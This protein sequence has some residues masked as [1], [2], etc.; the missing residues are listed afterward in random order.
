METFRDTLNYLYHLQFSG[1]KLGL[2]NIGKLLSYLGNPQNRWPA[3]H[4]AG[5][6][7][8]GSTAAFV[9]SILKEAGYRVALYTSPHLVDFRERIRVN[10]RFIPGEELVSYTRQLKPQIEKVKPT[11]FE[12]TT[13][14][15]FRYFADQN[16]DVAVVETG[17][18]GRLDATNLVNP[19]LTL[20]TSIGLDHQQY[21]GTDLPQIAREKAGIIKPG[22]PCF[23][24]NRSAEVLQVLRQR[25]REQ[26]APFHPLNP[27]EAIDICSQSIYGSTFHLQLPDVRLLDLKIRLAGPFQVANAALAVA[28]L[29]E[30][31]NFKI[32]EQNLR[33]GIK[34]AEWKGRLQ[35]VRD[36]P[37]VIVDVAH[38]PD[39]FRQVFDFLKKQLPNRPIR[40]MV[41]LAKDK[42][43]RQIAS[44]LAKNTRQV[45]VVA[46]FS[47]RELPAEQL[48]ES[49]KKEK[50]EVTRFD[51]LK[52]AY[53]ELLS[54]TGEN[55]VLL[56]IGS[57]YLAGAFFEKY[58]ILDFH[59]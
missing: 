16:V 56:I 31:K 59:K 53:T 11:F 27:A 46:N 24:N 43:H 38:N 58:K 30:I 41:G 34:L 29:R 42:D 52:T 10:D 28:A 9:Y 14:I 18:G 26:N 23:T 15:A 12:A 19:L 22:V 57:H 35:I 51:S 47:E 13:A 54:R 25:C 5:T 37:L 20:I 17:L 49:L 3:V 48:M 1:I 6:N 44:I 7:G 21:L 39:G 45:G 36:Q 33:S 4:I 40:A 32:T 8:K 50:A 55:E 2:E